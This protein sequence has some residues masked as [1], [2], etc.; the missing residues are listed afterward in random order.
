MAQTIKLK[1]SALQGTPPTTSS[2]ELG[3]VAINTYDGKM[4]IKKDDGTES[5]VEVGS[6]T[7]VTLSGTPNYITISG[8]VITRNQID[9]TTDVT[10][11]LPSV[12]MDADTA[13]LSGTQTFLGVKTLTSPILVTPVL[14][15]PTSGD[16]ANCTFPTLNQ[17]TTG[18]SDTIEIT[19]TGTSGNYRM[20]FTGASDATE[21]SASIFKDSAANLYYNP[22]TNILNAPNLVLSGD[23]T[24]NGTTTTIDTTN[25][26]VE[27]K[28]IEIGNV[29][30]PSDTT[31]D[32][33]GITLLGTTNK[34]IA[35]SNANDAWE[36]NQDLRVTQAVSPKLRLED[37]TNNSVFQAY[38]QDANSFVG[39]G[40]AHNLLIGTN[41]ITAITI[42]NSQDT[43]INNDLSVVGNAGI[44]TASPQGV[45]DL[46]SATGGRGIA[47]GGSSGTNHYSS[48]WSEYGNASIIVGAGLKGS[49]S[50]ASFLNPF[51][52]TYG[53]AAIELDSFS[54]D[55]MKFYTGADAART[56]DAAIVP[57]E[58]MRID[59]SGNVGIGTSSPSEKL[60][61]QGTAFSKLSY[62]AASSG[63]SNNS[64]GS[65]ILTGYYDYSGA[66][67]GLYVNNSGHSVIATKTSQPLIF[68]TNDTT[69][70][71][72][73]ATGNVGIGT[74]TPATAL[75]VDGVITATGGS[76]TN[77][78]AAEANVDT[79]LT[80]TAGT[81][82][83]PTVN[84]STGANAVI[85]S[86][87][88]SA[89]GAVTTGTQTFAGAKTFTAN[90][91]F[92][93][94]TNTTLAVISDD[95]GI[96]HIRAYGA[97]QGTGVI[98]VGQQATHGGGISYNGDGSPAF[99]AG[100]TN[101]NITFFRRAANVV[102]EVFSYPYNGNNVTFNGV[103]IAAGG[104]Q[105]A[106]HT[107]NDIDIT[108]EYSGADDH[109]MTSAAINARILDFGYT[110]NQ[111]AG[112]GLSGTTTLALD[113]G[114]LTA[115]GTLIAGDYL[116]AENGGADHRQLISSIPLSI[117]N[118]D[119]GWTA[120]VGDITGVTAGTGLT[121][122]G[123]S[124]TPT[125]N[126]IG[127]TGITANANDI[128]VN[129]GAFSTSDLSEGSNQYYTDA[130]AR[131][132]LAGGTGITYNSTTGSISL[133]DTGYVTGVTAG[134][135]LSGGGTSGTVTVT[136]DMSELT[137]MTAAMAGTDE[138]IVLDGGADRRKAANEIGLSIFSNDSGFTTNV[139][140]ITGVTAGTGLSGGGS[141][142]SVTLNVT[143][144]TT[145]QL[146]AGSLQLGSESFV[147]SDSVLMTAAAVQDK[148][149]SYGYST[150]TGDITGVTAGTGLTG[151]GTSGTPTLNVIGG[152]GITANANDI[153]L[154]TAGAGA[155]VYGSTSNSTKI[156]QI[157]LD[158]Y[159]RVTAI[160]TGGTGSMSS[161][162]VQSNTGTQVAVSNAEELNFING[163]NTTATVTNQTNPTVRI[164][165]SDTNLTWTAGTTA[166]P[167]V[168][169]STGANAVIPSA[170]ASASGAVTTGTQTFAGAKTFSSM[171][172]ADA[173]F[174]STV[175]TGTAPL[176]VTSTTVVANLNADLLDGNQAT[177]FA[178]SAH[179]HT[180]LLV[181]SGTPKTGNFSAVTNTRYLVDTSSSAITAILPSSPSVGDL[182]SFVDLE[183][184]FSTNNLTLDPNGS[185][186]LR[187]ADDAVVNINN[188]N[189]S[190]IYTDATSG[191]LP[192]GAAPVDTPASSGGGSGFQVEATVQTAL[193][194]AS[195]GKLYKLDCTG[196]S[197]NVTLPASPSEGEE[198]HFRF[199]NGSAPSSSNVTF[200][201]N[202]SEIEDASEDLVWD[203]DSPK[204]FGLLYL[205]QDGWVII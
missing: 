103:V 133:T 119:S 76:S 32:G 196:G 201:R 117:F 98:E 114:E 155:A 56:K 12:N 7:D 86:A 92:D 78:N 51:T 129:M 21:N 162:N 109:L 33:G 20:I 13:H 171:I 194:T 173:G 198:V 55:G 145:A 160:S 205:T 159:G 163:T 204:Y 85:P 184:S 1:R 49:T 70:A 104:L 90:A 3:E 186:I 68:S 105:L 43:S 73:N 59:S 167:T 88:A 187:S 93:S 134:T 42:N 122:G 137:D 135:G 168:N 148:I 44:G 37:T 183:G 15:T 189:T 27:D 17:N 151:G 146:A 126:V 81:T 157:T 99:A 53:Y 165:A 202:G 75:D 116:I 97:S 48:I 18:S 69:R 169:S 61:V 164:D 4:Y 19:A 149:T 54:E 62:A 22:S 174:T 172:S 83:G 182:V 132:A 28:N 176:T 65:L 63:F 67:L 191:W 89:S 192:T 26:L 31:A 102:T 38:A 166:G 52:G 107:M 120:N 57:V 195:V 79:N 96:S 5:I 115:G 39:T 131:S 11:V 24:V 50:A 111:A 199:V 108:S 154:T 9:L 177:A 23:L 45:L 10:G 36:F 16:L 94:G 193:F 127:G 175:A 101:D 150:T 152:T 84:S 66:A 125:L 25:L 87:S 179:N 74:T 123:T 143:G 60:E 41:N 124:G 35:W 8:Q 29:T 58:R 156:D 6:S 47:W 185:N 71:V 46:G 158:A 72:I 136:L 130:R 128:A 64:G 118:N 140:D 121:G 112:V 40:S 178:T 113:L 82:A 170:S 30:T 2:L 190:W 141:S 181:T 100:E 77:W 80:W 161:F 110:G 200:L 106:G 138:F 14:G 197:F 95:T 203:V 147:D 91:T 142:G 34:T 144:L 139:G 153:A 180:G 188:W